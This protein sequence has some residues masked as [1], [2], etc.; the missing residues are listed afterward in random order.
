MESQRKRRQ[1]VKEGKKRMAVA[2]MAMEMSKW[3]RVEGEN[4]K[5]NPKRTD[6]RL[7]FR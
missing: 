1:R 5:E 7:L 6:P 4:G 3:M 2:R